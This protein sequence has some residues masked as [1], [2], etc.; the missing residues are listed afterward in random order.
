MSSCHNDYDL[1]TSAS[2][3]RVWS[4]GQERSKSSLGGDDE[5]GVKK[6]KKSDDQN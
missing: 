6:E 3:G 1:E 2:T 5:I 4:A